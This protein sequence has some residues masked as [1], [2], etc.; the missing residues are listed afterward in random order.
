MLYIAHGDK[1]RDWHIE[2]IQ[3]NLQRSLKFNRS[4][5]ASFVTHSLKLMVERCWSVLEPFL[6]FCVHLQIWTDM[7]A[8]FSCWPGCEFSR[9]LVRVNCMFLKC[10]VGVAECKW[11]TCWNIFKNL[12]MY[13]LYQRK[14]LHKL[15][16][17][18]YFFSVIK[19]LNPTQ[20]MAEKLQLQVV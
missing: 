1:L 12:I 20:N 6:Q 10:V 13:P 3:C 5:N 18:F 9:R 8:I 4:V 15:T 7:C 19:L 11:L 2:S 17:G 14:H 16:N